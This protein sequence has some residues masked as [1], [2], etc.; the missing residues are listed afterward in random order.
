M[1]FFFYSLATRA[2]LLSGAVYAT[3]K[4]VM[5]Y[6]LEAL[7]T[8]WEEIGPKYQYMLKALLNGGGYFGLSTGLF[9]L[10]LLIIPFRHGDVWAGYAI[11]VIGLVG[12][13]PLGLI[14]RGVKKNTAGNPPLVVMVVIVAL[15]VLGLIACVLGY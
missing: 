2:T 10:V 14:V 5:P 15:L 9:M 4:T 7:E 13:L 12:A 8:S 6:H 1:S 3:R 11:G